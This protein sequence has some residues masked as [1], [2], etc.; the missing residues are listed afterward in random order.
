MAIYNKNIM[1][2]LLA[3]LLTSAIIS[4]TNA[5]LP[6]KSSAEMRHVVLDTNN[7]DNINNLTQEMMPIDSGANTV[8]VISKNYKL[9][10]KIT[11]PHN[12][13]LLFNGGSISGEGCLEGQGSYI[14]GN[15]INVFDKGINLIG[16]WNFSSISPDWFIGN[17]LEKIQKAFDVSIANKSCQIEID[18]SYNITGGTIYADRGHHSADEI[19]QWSRRNLIISGRGE[20]RIIK[21][22]AGFMFSANALSI[23]FVFDKIH[24]RGYV[25]KPSDL[26]TI[27][28]MSVFD[29]RYLG[30]LRVTNC[31]FCHCGCVYF[32]KGGV[33]TPMQGVLSIG[34]QYTKNKSVMHA[35]ECWYSQ[36]IGDVAEDGMT[37]IE[38]ESMGSN[39]RD[40]K[41]SNCCVEGFFRPQTVAINLN[42]NA[43]GL[44]ITDN[45][46]E[47]NYC[48]VRIP[49]N[50]SGIITGNTFHSRGQRIHKEDEVRCIELAKTSEIEITGN[51]VVASD[52]NMYLFYFDTSSPYYSQSQKLYGNNHVA[53]KTM[54]SNR[55][56]NIKDL[57]VVAETLEDSYIND[58]TNNMKKSF[59][60]ISG[61]SVMITNHRGMTTIS[62]NNLVISSP[63]S[64]GSYSGHTT[65]AKPFNTSFSVNGAI[66]DKDKNLMGTLFVTSVGDIGLRMNKPGTYSGVITYPHK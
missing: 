14:G 48:S 35:N 37:F 52:E 60:Q 58:I 38:G 25:S 56:D 21:E 36:F 42:C 43:P 24:F 15:L 45:Y 9:D 5:Q 6:K 20:G 19:S 65:E 28:D 51:N 62:L 23:D 7:I 53:G 22:D 2:M 18:R 57:R 10:N 1:S 39:I 40:L 55:E 3:I 27:V 49:R 4:C 41:I 64:S 44:S 16:D 11:I 34:N 8:Y 61:G 13:I 32:Q 54:L 66:V 59:P 63:I 29:C 30:N 47:A 50:V 26:N 31:S 33:N 17:D 46:F 12:S